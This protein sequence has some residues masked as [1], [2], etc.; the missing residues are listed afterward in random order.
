M[1][2]AIPGFPAQSLRENLRIPMRLGLPANED[3]W[4]TFVIPGE[5][6]AEWGFDPDEQ[7][8]AP[9]ERRERPLCA[10]EFAGGAPVQE[11]WGERQPT[12][13]TI[14]LLDEEYARVEGF[15]HVELH[16]GG[17][18]PVRYD[19]TRTVGRYALDV[20]EVWQVECRA[21]DGA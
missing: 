3:E 8:P 6:A 4:P 15:S 20:V 13:V 19:Y 16:M 10:L 11:H 14:T 1:A 12:S 5:G 9:V 7:R 21:E 2:Q 17:A 18:T